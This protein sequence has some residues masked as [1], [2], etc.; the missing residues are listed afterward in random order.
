VVKTPKK[1]MRC[2]HRIPLAVNAPDWRHWEQF[3]ELLHQDELVRAMV[4]VPKSDAGA[5]YLE[6]AGLPNAYLAL[7]AQMS[8]PIYPIVKPIWSLALPVILDELQLTN[9]A[10]FVITGLVARNSPTLAQLAEVIGHMP[11]KLVVA[12]DADV[13]VPSPFR[14]IATRLGE[15]PLETLMLLPWPVLGAV[16]VRK[17]MRK[18][19]LA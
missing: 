15:Y 1:G 12:G 19:T 13:V 5:C 7:L 16:V 18:E 11:R 14:R 3:L 10:P 6:A 2:P 17:F 9:V 4:P 8:S